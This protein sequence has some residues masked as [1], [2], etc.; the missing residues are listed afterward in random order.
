MV[1]RRGAAVTSPRGRF[2]APAAC[3]TPTR[4]HS[5]QGEEREAHNHPPGRRWASL[6]VAVPLMEIEAGY[7][8]GYPDH[9]KPVEY[10]L[11]AATNEGLRFSEVKM[12]NMMERGVPMF[13]IPWDQI[14]S[15]LYD[16]A[17]KVNRSAHGKTVAVTVAGGLALGA[18]TA[19]THHKRVSSRNCPLDVTLTDGAV[20]H[21]AAW[22][23]LAMG[24]A[25]PYSS[26]SGSSAMV[27]VVVTAPFF[28]AVFFD[29]T[30]A[31]KCTTS[32]SFPSAAAIDTRPP[33]L[34]FSTRSRL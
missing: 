34:I 26:S 1:T 3:A 28:L 6:P 15:A 10:G 27:I 14:R 29:S 24:G 23:F 19:A 2:A 9:P 8:G 31:S 11:L 4:K 18:A 30:C 17:A 21:F 32:P 25:P 5:C 20:A 7:L 22:W 33:S 13:T 12:V 16:P